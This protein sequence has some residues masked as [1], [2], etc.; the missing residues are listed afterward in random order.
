[1]ILHH[2]LVLG[3]GLVLGTSLPLAAYEQIAPPP[4]VVLPAARTPAESLA[5]ITVPAEMRVELVV[6][7]PLVMDPIDIAWGAD[8][9]LWV[10]EMTDYP[11][12]VDGKPGG[13]VRFL[14]STRND[15][16]YDK[17]TVFAEGLNFPSSVMPWRK[18]VLVT[19]APNIL[20]LEDTDGDGKADLIEKRFTGLGEGNQQHR[21]NSLQ[22]GLDGWVYHANGDSGGTVVSVRTGQTLVLGQRDL[23][24]NPDTGEFDPLAGRTQY[25]RNRDDWGNWFGGNNS[26]PLWHYALEDRYLRRNRF[27]APPNSTITVS[28]IPGAAPIY[29]TSQTIARFNDAFGANRFT[30]ACGTMIYR[31][32]LLGSGYAGNAFICEPVHNLVHRE[33]VQPS[34]VTFTSQRA[35]QEQTSEF[36]ASSDNWSRFT[37]ARTGPDGALYLVDMYRLV[38]E[39]PTWIPEQWQKTLG[40]LR[41][42]SD[43]G[44]IYRVY[45]KTATLRSVPRLD[46][47]DAAGLVEALKSPN[48]TVRDLAQQQLTWRQE[49]SATAAL[50]S[51]S[52][53]AALPQTRAQALWSLETTGALTPAAVAS[54]LKDRHAGVR[55]QAVQLSEK[56]AASNPEL[57]SGLTAL[58]DDPDAAVRQQ[59]A[60]SLGE[61]K[62]PA[63]GRALAQLVRKAED[64]LIL[65]A[66]MSSALPHADTMLS[67]MNA[68]GGANRTLIEIAIATQNNKALADVLTTISAP[69]TPAYPASQFA[70]MAQLLDTLG[71]NRKTLAQLRSNADGPMTAALNAAAALIDA[72]RKI[73]PDAQAALQQRNAAVALLGR[74]FD[75]QEDDFAAL[76]GL[77][78]PPSPEA[79]QLAAV[80]A[81]GNLNLPAIPQRLIASWDNYAPGVRAAVLDLLTSRAQWATPLLNRIDANRGMIAGIDT[82]RRAALTQHADPRIATRALAIF[83]S[84]DLDRQK[85]IDRYLT[86]MTNLQGDE[87]RGKTVFSNTCSICHQL[88]ETGGRAVGPDLGALS[89][90]SRP[91][92]V[93]HILDPNRALEDKYLLY[94]ASTTDGR[95]L[96]GM[97]AGEAGDSVTLMGIDGTEQVILRSGLKSITSTR[98]SLMPDGLEGAIDP[99]A[100]ADLV[101]FVATAGGRRAAAKPA[102]RV[103]G[104]EPRLV[105]P[106]ADGT[107]VLPAAAATPYG[108]KIKYMPEFKAFGWW[109]SADHVAWEVNVTAAGDYDVQMEWSV[110]DKS[111]NGPYTLSAGAHTLSGRVAPSGGWESFKAANIGRIRLET[112]RQELALKPSGKLGEALMDLRELRLTPVSGRP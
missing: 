6:A 74:G 107:L 96:A 106:S 50:E 89:D 2:R 59:V 80:R 15:G 4:N 61:W 42:G 65:A 91:Y 68:D 32:D 41:A 43:K 29:P 92:L 26:N 56:F 24:T 104:N 111:A 81:V 102:T 57:L 16:R 20:Y 83:G 85:V 72:A 11:N 98:R 112:G 108:P 12:G 38:I 73:A 17:S 76:A 55:R 36:F 70:D 23:R 22:W 88:P 53:E 75:R 66:A 49:K 35:P 40:D 103:A 9:R 77:I 62:S 105:V 18:G 8:G 82:S 48:G 51:L 1:M 63:A 94:T 71:R 90:H 37:S 110:S 100:M 27:L 13:R 47:A 60:Y 14:E 79:L 19:A 109:T 86:A 97:L 45:P 3:L 30:S 21:V 93:T 5:A 46:R 34:G 10:V 7:E 78:A 52:R 99:Q 87:A 33:I 64:P 69:R 39:H 95:T 84:T 101:A 28:K 67:Q 25:G 44:R 58:V 31:D 54:A